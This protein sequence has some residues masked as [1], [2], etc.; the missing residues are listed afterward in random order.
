MKLLPFDEWIREGHA[1]A[2]LHGG[3]HEL[4]EAA[5]AGDERA[6]KLCRE[7]YAD[8]EER[9]AQANAEAER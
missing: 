7:S 8:S 3:P 5:I 6:L 9:C 2:I 1:N 4:Y